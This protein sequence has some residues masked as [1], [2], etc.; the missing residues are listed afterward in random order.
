MCSHS[1]SGAS[2]MMLSTVSYTCLDSVRKRRYPFLDGFHC[3]GHTKGVLIYDAWTFP[4]SL[5]RT[6]A[7][8]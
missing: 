7:A 6:D 5:L 8:S 4:A 1:G 3:R 2:A